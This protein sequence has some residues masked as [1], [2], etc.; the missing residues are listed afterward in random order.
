MT[1]VDLKALTALWSIDVAREPRSVTLAK[2]GKTAW[3]NHLVG[4]SI[5]KLEGEPGWKS[6][7]KPKP[8]LLPPSPLRSPAGVTLA[9]SLGYAALLSPD[10]DRLFVARHALGA[11]GENA[12]FGASTLDVLVTSTD[13]PLSPRRHDRLPFLRA[14]KATIGAE[15]VVPAAPLSPFTQ[16]RALAY[17]ASTRSI[18]VASEGDDR[19]VE[20][21]AG[22]V[23][24]SLAVLARYDVGGGYD[25]GLPVASTGGAPAGLALSDDEKTVYVWCRST[26]DLVAQ[27]LHSFDADGAPD[28][29]A[30]LG[31]KITIHLA[32]DTLDAD[33]ALGRRLFHNASDRV[34]SGG[35]ACSGCH[36][37]G[38]DDGH[39]WHEGKFNTTDGTHTNFVG[40]QADIP[41]EE[42]VKGAPR[43]TP[44]LAGL[45][46][47]PGPYGWHGES[48]DL[49]ARLVGGFGLH[50]WGGMPKHEPGNLDARSGRIAKFL[51]NGLVPPPKVERELDAT[52]KRGKELFS[53]EE[54]G[55]ASCHVPEAGYTN[56]VAYPLAK[57]PP[58]D[59]FD[60]EDSAVF[61][62]PSLR[63]V[64]GRAPYFHDGRAPSLEWIIDNN[65]GDRMG[66]TNHLSGVDRAALVAF[67]RTL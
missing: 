9:A 13:A 42:G 7:P 4:A 62:T 32:D 47:A 51:R 53:S 21:D 33:G 17:R 61:K 50:R 28:P 1:A 57:L 34:T 40:H 55:C 14:D 38:R 35:L 22:A 59:G 63:W 64:A 25:P 11:I 18:L 60:D 41:Q 27:P 16:P 24:P 65:T 54:V 29:A 67:L 2:D 48:V 58:R 46:D 36:P 23:D 31:E 10:G 49:P 20:L 44:M 15:L 8:V 3:I 37:E 5:T 56:R 39:V 66:K 45:V 30:T 19:V 26:Y 12:W 52:E 43:R 6:A